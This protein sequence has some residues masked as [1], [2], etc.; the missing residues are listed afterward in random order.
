MMFFRQQQIEVGFECLQFRKDE[1]LLRALWALG[2]SPRVPPPWF[3][4][5]LPWVWAAARSRPR[6]LCCPGPLGPWPFGALG[7]EVVG[8]LS[9]PPSLSPSPRPSP[10]LVPPRPSFAGGSGFFPVGRQ[11]VGLQYMYTGCNVRREELLEGQKGLVGD[12]ASPW[13][14][15]FPIM[16]PV[17]VAPNKPKKG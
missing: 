9:A 1:K 14:R 12:Q 15:R 7:W 13:A 11:E 2:G 6:R 10:S 3:S 16:N 17:L 4:L 8:G 5:G